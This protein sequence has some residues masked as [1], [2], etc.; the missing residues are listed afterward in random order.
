MSDQCPTPER[1]VFIPLFSDTPTSA[2]D[3]LISMVNNAM[4]WPDIDLAASLAHTRERKTF[5]MGCTRC[6]K[7]VSTD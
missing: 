6:G 5:A 2:T 7:S 1:C 3:D 4:T